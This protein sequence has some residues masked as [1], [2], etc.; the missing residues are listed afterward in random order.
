M[1]LV[2]QPIDDPQIEVLQ[3]CKTLFWN[4]VQIGRVGGI[5]DPVAERRYVAMAQQERRDGQRP[6]RPFDHAAFAG[7]DRPRFQDR[8]IGTARRL[9]KAISKAQPDMGGSAVIEIHRNAALAVHHQR[10][11]IVDAMGLVGVLMGEKHRI[12]MIDIGVEQLLAQ[13]GRGID[14]HPRHAAFALQ[15]GH[16]RAAPAPVLWVGRVAGAPAEC[17]TRHPRRRTAA[18][19]GE[20][21]RHAASSCRG[22][23]VNSLKKLSVVAFASSSKLTP[24]ISASA[25]AVSTTKAGSLRLPRNFPG[26]R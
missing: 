1:V 6:A 17:R 24:L 3:R 5:V 7:F 11:Q 12:D 16:Q 13:I 18:Q 9:L 2:A 21:Q 23:L 10:T 25:L 20:R 19:D 14:H 8:R 15:L 4:V 26:A 22:T